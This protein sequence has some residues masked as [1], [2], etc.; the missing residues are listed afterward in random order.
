V[1]AVGL[2]EIQELGTLSDTEAA[3]FLYKLSTGLDRVS[4]VDV[5]RELAA[6]RERLLTGGEGPS[7]IKLLFDE[8]A[9]LTN[10]AEELKVQSRR[11][12]QLALQRKESRVAIAGLEKE[13][14]ARERD[15]RR[16]ELA[17]AVHAR[18]RERQDHERELAA[19]SD[20]PR[21]AHDA[22][23]RLDRA[24]AARRKA[25]H[26][27]RRTRARQ[28]VVRKQMAQLG[29]SDIVWRHAP[30]IEALL[31]QE[32]WIAMLENQARAAASDVETLA[33]Q[34]RVEH[35]A[36][37]L[38]TGSPAIDDARHS[39]RA[40]GGLRPLVRDLREARVRARQADEQA[41]LCEQ[42]LARVKGE[43]DAAL[44]SRPQSDVL[45]AVETAGQHVAQLRRRVQLD[46]RLDEMKQRETELRAA[47]AE[48]L[49]RQLLSPWMLVGLGALFVVGV[50]AILTGL[51]LPQSFLGPTGWVLAVL[52]AVG[53]GSA[54]AAK[55]LLERSAAR[56]YEA[57]QQQ[58]SALAGQAEEAKRERDELDSRLP[59]GGGPML[60]RLQAAE[61]DLS[62]LE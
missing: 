55:V 28:A 61:K 42:A 40:L 33:E 27:L 16:I 51:L 37:G 45:T 24:L 19:L 38:G 5:M 59:K 18:W 52:G 4:L 26:R 30:R 22:V 50:A 20:A 56:R 32:A 44:V 21:V 3:D 15:A 11:Y 62:A 36:L 2:R 12:A 25:R 31:E 58:L 53:V 43:V 35:E 46:Q 10:Q 17:C 47:A 14:A 9:R 54:A 29:A 60:T 34:V 41:R 1:F 8:R 23:E 13:V 49:Q 7:Q 48:W 6:S 57:C 39:P